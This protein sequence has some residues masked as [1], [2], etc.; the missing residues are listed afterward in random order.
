MS[1]RRIRADNPGPFT[2]DGSVTYLLGDRDLVIVDP[3]PAVDSHI[4]AL[5]AAVAGAER[6]TVVLTHGHGDHAGGVDT[7]LAALGARGQ[8]PVALV[9]AGHPAVRAPRPGEG[10]VFEGGHLEA[11]ATPGHTRDHLA[12]LWREEAALFAGDHLLGVGETTW[13]GEYPGCVAD[14]LDS[15]AR[16]R[17]LGLRTVHPGHGPDLRDPARAIDRFEAHRRRRIE[18]VRELQEGAEALRGDALFARV[19]GDRIPSGL[20]RAARSSLAA[21]EEFLATR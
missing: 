11:V 18:Q 12:W 2:F 21:I 5:V 10:I 3:G 7:L 20:D 19:Y 6:I 17:T 8:S 14:Y 9:G 16:L 15:L 4:R 13:V 1:L